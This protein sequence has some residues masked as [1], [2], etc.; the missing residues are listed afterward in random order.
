M[1]HIGFK[2]HG[3]RDLTVFVGIVMNG[4][5]KEQ[6]RKLLFH[7]DDCNT[8]E[9]NYFSIMNAY[10]R[11]LPDVQNRVLKN[12]NDTTFYQKLKVLSSCA[13]LKILPNSR[14]IEIE[15]FLQININSEDVVQRIVA[16]FKYRFDQRPAV[17]AIMKEY[18][19]C[20]KRLYNIL[21]DSTPEEMVET[22]DDNHY[23]SLVQSL[24][25]FS[26]IKPQLVSLLMLWMIPAKVSLI[27]T[28][29]DIEHFTR[30]A[31]I[32]NSGLLSYKENLRN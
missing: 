20:A 28:R 7:N 11:A 14:P 22:M 9:K 6:I 3:T 17:I 12:L 31:G 32:Q 24:S 4:V 19:S 30:N 13:I 16:K 23:A 15:Q 26:I 10:S 2:L 5:D 1:V 8:M 25:D 27:H 21:L 29:E 18:P